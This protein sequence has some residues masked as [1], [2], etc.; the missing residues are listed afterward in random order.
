M[1][2]YTM[3]PLQSVRNLVRIVAW[4]V[5]NRLSR[6]VVVP[7]IGDQRH[8]VRRGLTGATGNNYAGLHEYLDTA[9]VLHIPRPSD[10]FFDIGANVGSYS[11]LASGICGVRTWAF[12]PDPDAASAFLRNIHLNGLA[13]QVVLHEFVVGD[14]GGTM[15]FTKGLGPMNHV[16]IGGGSVE[17][18]P[19]KSS[20]KRSLDGLA[21]DE[22]PIM[23]KLDV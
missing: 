10:L 23:I 3:T 5:R 9:L 19:C 6:E 11:V 21:N 17:E 1:T 12:E 7:W 13:D 15:A 14:T 20:L 18:G 2:Q 16:T 22:C 8:A 4:L